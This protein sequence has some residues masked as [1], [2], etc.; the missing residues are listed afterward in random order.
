PGNAEM[1]QTAKLADIQIFKIVDDIAEKT[2]LATAE[3]DQAKRLTA[4]LEKAYRELVADS[5]VWTRQQDH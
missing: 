2:D 5:H 1:I 3:P 4:K